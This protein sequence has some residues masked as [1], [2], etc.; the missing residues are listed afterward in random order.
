MRIK[1]MIH[2]GEYSFANEKRFYEQATRFF[3]QENPEIQFLS[4]EKLFSIQ[5]G[6][7][8]IDFD[9]GYFNLENKDFS[10]Y[11]YIISSGLCA[12]LNP[13]IQPGDILLPACATPFIINEEEKKGTIYSSKKTCFTNPMNTLIKPMSDYEITAQLHEHILAAHKEF[14]GEQEIRSI[15]DIH[16]H[17]EAH[18]LTASTIFLPSQLHNHAFYNEES[19]LQNL[20]EHVTQTYDAL[21]CETHAMIQQ[22]KNNTFMYTLG[23]D[24]PYKGHEYIGDVREEKKWHTT[25]QEMNLATIYL[26]K[27][28]L[29]G[30]LL[31]TQGKILEESSAE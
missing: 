28:V 19:Q 30:L 15:Q 14:L 31:Q 18:I 2:R 8:R 5:L 27:Y 7:L 17:K 4:E 22:Q 26:F 9:Y 1:Y 24:K 11:D 20:Q 10:N 6:S 16:V 23:I 25:I 13:N 29:L 21:N 3:S 12:V